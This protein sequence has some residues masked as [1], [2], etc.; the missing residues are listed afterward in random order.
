MTD[1]TRQFATYN[2]H[3]GRVEIVDLLDIELG[4]YP[5]GTI[6]NEVFRADGGPVTIPGSH[7]RLTE[8]GLVEE[9]DES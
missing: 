5:V 1:T 8:K 9:N 7:Y 4:E 6:F 2:E 3:T